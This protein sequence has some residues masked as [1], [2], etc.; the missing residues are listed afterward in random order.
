MKSPDTI[1]SRWLHPFVFGA[2]MVALVYL[3]G[4][5]R[6]MDFLRPEFGLLLVP[7]VFIA[8]GFM[9]AAIAGN[10]TTDKDASTALRAAVLL[11]PLIFLVGVPDAMLGELAFKNRFVGT[12]TITT[13]SRDPSGE[14]F[15]WEDGQNEEEASLVDTTRPRS[16]AAGECFIT[17]L[18]RRAGRYEGRRVVFTGMIM[19]DEALKEH[20][21]GRDT[22]VYRFLITC[23]AADALPLAVAV[24]ADRAEPF[25]N[26]QWVRVSGTFSLHH[27]DDKSFPLVTDAALEPIEAPVIPYLF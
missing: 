2:W 25:A 19:R 15:P 27:V 23:C 12:G 11:L 4:S 14:R 6:Y 22:A 21:G 20:F 5:R 1:F 26:D 7:A 17:D 8:M 16:R 3:L 10:R 9:I 24:D 13:N 18:Y